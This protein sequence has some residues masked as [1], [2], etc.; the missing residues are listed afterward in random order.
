MNIV[1]FVNSFLPKIGGRELVVVHLANALYKQGHKVRVV[2]PGGYFKN[3]N[4]NFDYPVHR[5][6]SIANLKK[7]KQCLRDDGTLE[8]AKL[9][10]LLEEK[11]QKWQL[12]HN[13]K[14]WGY[15]IVHAHNTYPTGYAAAQLKQ[16]INL[17]LVITPHG[18]DI[19]KIPELKHGLRLNPHLEK[20]I[21]FALEGADAITA[22]SNSIRDAIIDAGAKNEKIHNIPNGVDL[23]R[24]SDNSSIDVRQWLGVPASARLV[25]TVGNYHPRKG[26]EVLVKSMPEVLKVHTMAKLVIVGGKTEALRPIIDDLGLNDAVIL[27][28]SIPVPGSSVGKSTAD[29]AQ[30]DYLAA[31]LQQSEMYISSSTDEGAEGLSLALLEGMAAKLPIIATDISGNR[32][33]ITDGAN[34]M[35]VAPKSELA[36][37]SAISH[38]LS[39][40]QKI[41]R[42]GEGALAF[43]SEYGWNNIADIYVAL[44]EKVIQIS[45]R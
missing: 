16:S 32:D 27:T 1:L 22:I 25:V 12:H 24:F 28:G 14:K 2:G 44:Y 11:L 15:D 40:D 38:L 19:H 23:D 4:Q 18:Q 26:H 37:A 31:L 42:L 10:A 41:A 36:L 29:N 39:D 5:F 30:K 34:G 9:R 3:K 7:W 20:R 45:K 33:V 17:P 43:A 35:L 8:S 13:L 21:R 6:P